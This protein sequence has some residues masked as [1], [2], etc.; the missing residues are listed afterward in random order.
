MARGAG[1][2]TAAWPGNSGTRNKKQE[3]LTILGKFQR[4]RRRHSKH[5][6]NMFCEITKFVCYRKRGRWRWGWENV[7]TSPMEGCRAWAVSHGKRGV[8]SHR[9]AAWL[10]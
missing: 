8:I 3:G 6:K 4:G 1:N 5:R 7:Q 9:K 2:Y 10:D